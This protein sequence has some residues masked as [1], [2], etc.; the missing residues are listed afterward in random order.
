MRVLRG[1]SGPAAGFGIAVERELTI[2]R[3]GADITIADPGLAGRHAV[4]RPTAH[5]L[6][7]EDLGSAGGSF[8]DGERIAAPTPLTAGS[9]VGLGGSVMTVELSPDPVASASPPAGVS[10][11]SF[12]GPAPGAPPRPSRRAA[13]VIGL[14][15]VLTVVGTGVGIAA[16]GGSSK[17]PSSSSV[18]SAAPT[19][20]A[21]PTSSAHLVPF[22]THA[23]QG[24]S[25]LL[26]GS[27][28]N[29]LAGTEDTGG[30]LA[31]VHI[32]LHHGSE[33]PAH[34]HTREAECFYVITGHMT[35]VAGGRTLHAGPGDFVYLPRNVEHDYTVDGGPSQVLVIAVPAGLER[36]F[37]ALSKDPS[38]LL[39]IAGKY[40]ILPGKLP[41]G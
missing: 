8:V 36:F 29:V 26:R 4:I 14:V 23:G 11:S 41:T 33:P 7:I 12:D 35:F 21:S 16:G 6:E 32:D 22:I 1:I 40:G 10:S 3:E 39:T 20:A 13:V 17:K 19:T 27:R 34:I 5:G 9:K 31:V 15:A 24:T 2:G 18:A 25:V 28:Y 37:I 38:A 30:E